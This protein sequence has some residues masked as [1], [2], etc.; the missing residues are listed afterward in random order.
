[1]GKPVRILDLAEDVIRLSGLE[2]YRDI[3]IAFCGLRPGEKLSEEL[4]TYAEATRAV[5]QE[6]LLI[7]DRPAYLEHAH[8]DERI[9]ALLA[10]AATHDDAAVLAQLSA[11]IPTFRARVAETTG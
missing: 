5:T 9:D 2:P 7:V 8:I 1:M 10:V 11:L 3:D 6:R 4:F